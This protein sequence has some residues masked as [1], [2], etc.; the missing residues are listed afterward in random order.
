MITI[1]QEASTILG[2]RVEPGRWKAVIERLDRLGYPTRKQANDLIVMLC[3]R[4]EQMEESYGNP[5]PTE[6]KTQTPIQ[7]PEK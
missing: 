1:A 5:K 2:V 4:V 6:P 7:S 3:E